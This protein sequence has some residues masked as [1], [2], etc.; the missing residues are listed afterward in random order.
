MQ[1]QRDKERREENIKE[2]MKLTDEEEDRS[3]TD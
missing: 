3:Q 2:R 1:R